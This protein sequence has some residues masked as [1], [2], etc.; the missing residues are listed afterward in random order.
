[1][2]R[3][4]AAVYFALFVVV[5]AGA[6][7]LLGVMSGPAVSLDGP[8]HSQG[9]QFSAGGVTYTVDSVGDGEATLTAGEEEITLEEGANVSLGETQH[10][11]HFPADGGVQVLP[12]GQYYDDYR[13]EL[14]VQDHYDERRA[15]VWAVLFLSFLAAIILLAAAYMPTRG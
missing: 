11:A 6:Y 7:G 12:S 2:Q 3:R 10:F 5:G 9:D 13:D 8:T 14:A 1:M 15:G 4:A